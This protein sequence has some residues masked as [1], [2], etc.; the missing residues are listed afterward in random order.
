MVAAVE[1]M[2]EESLT[3]LK[4]DYIDLYWLHWD[5]PYT[6]VEETLRAL[7]DP[8]LSGKVRFIGFSVTYA[9]KVA[10]AA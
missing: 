8:V 3:R 10:R 1:K 9:W 4:T 2:L 5:D 6:P 7:N